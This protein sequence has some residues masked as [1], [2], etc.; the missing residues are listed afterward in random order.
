V[1]EQGWQL[2]QDWDKA[3]KG[4]KDLGGTIVASADRSKRDGAAKGADKDKDAVPDN[5]PFVCIICDG[6]YKS[7]VVTRCR[8]YFCEP[9]A[10][11]RYRK[12]PTCAAC[13]AQ[14]NGVFNSAKDL[15]KMLDRKK[16]RE[17][18]RE[19]KATAEG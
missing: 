10:L 6:P 16:E 7:P 9:C 12:D 18:E 3:T 19:E 4:K 17:A 13:S 2:D 5:I 11:K 1:F 14:T 8:H 15:Q